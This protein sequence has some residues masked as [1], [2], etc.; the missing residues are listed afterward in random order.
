MK[1][2]F[3]PYLKHLGKTPEEQ[4]EKNKP[5]MTWL[6]QKMEEKVTEEEAEE[7]SKNWEI[8]KEIIDNNRPSGEKLFSRG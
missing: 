8:V 6:Q 5:L 3:A 7:N 2:T 4:L 1:Q